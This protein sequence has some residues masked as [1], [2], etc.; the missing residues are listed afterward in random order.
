MVTRV[1]DNTSEFFISTT[2]ATLSSTNT[3]RNP[4]SDYVIDSLRQIDVFS[5]RTEQASLIAPTD[6][7]KIWLNNNFTPVQP[8]YFNQV[9]AGWEDVTFNTFFT[10]VSGQIHTLASVAGTNTITGL[11]T[12]SLSAY[13]DGQQFVFKAAATNTG[14]VTLNVDSIGSRDVKKSQGENIIAGDFVTGQVVIVVFNSTTNVFEW[15]NQNVETLTQ[16][17]T[18]S[19]VAGTNTIT[20]TSGLSLSAY[21]DGDQFVFKTVAANT[22]T[23]TL[24]VDSIGAV[25]VGKNQGSAIASGDFAISQVVIVVYNATTN[26]FEWVNQTQLSAASRPAFMV[27]NAANQLNLTGAGTVATVIFGTETFDQ[28]N[29]VSANV[30]TAPVTGRYF[31]SCAVKLTGLVTPV[32][33]TLNIVTS[34][35][36][37]THTIGNGDLGSTQVDAELAIF[38]DMDASDTASV[39]VS[40][41]GSTDVWDINS[42]PANFFSGYQTF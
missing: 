7:S 34:N 6:Q 30:F 38:C 1:F 41:S 27:K 12:V 31:F 36:T 5:G 3:F 19:S 42:N 37:F 35:Q 20:G 40:G 15:V 11:S 32:A 18:L 22:S 10:K 21:T 17:R 16:I 28:G 2:G 4:P 29:N 23:V 13:T 14:V 33:F 25:P 9:T 26:V 39:L 8:Q 24:N